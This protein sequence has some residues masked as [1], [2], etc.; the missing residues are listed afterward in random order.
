MTMTDELD[1]GSTEELGAAESIG[2]D[3]SDA[4]CAEISVLFGDYRIT[5]EDVKDAAKWTYRRLFDHEEK[6]EPG[7][8]SIDLED[9]E[10]VTMRST[11]VAHDDLPPLAAGDERD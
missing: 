10:E 6:V 8:I 9:H 2:G 1:R 5:D 4:A 3:V 7:G 11:S